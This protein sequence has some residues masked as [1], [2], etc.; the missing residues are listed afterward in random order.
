MEPLSDACVSGVCACVRVCGYGCPCGEEKEKGGCSSQK[1]VATKF[2]VLFW[3]FTFYLV[4]HLICTG[5][6]KR[7]S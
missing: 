3:A 2:G 5:V 6:I 1:G 7:F 4:L